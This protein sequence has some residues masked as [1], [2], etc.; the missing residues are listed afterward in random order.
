MTVAY[1]IFIDF[2]GVLCD[3]VKEAYL[4]SR[5]AYYGTDVHSPL[6]NLYEIFR[7]YRYLITN[8][9]Q[10]YFLLKSCEIADS[11][12]IEKTFD[13]LI[14]GGQN[15][16]SSN[17][18]NKFLRKRA[19]LINAEFDFWNQLE[20]PT[21]FLTKIRDRFLEENYAILSTKTKT[22]IIAKLKY[23]QV[24]FDED[25]IFGKEDIVGFTKGEFINNY[26]LKKNVKKAILIDDSYENIVS[27]NNKNIMTL[28]TDWGYVN[29]KK[30]G[31]SEK[32]ILD[33]LLKESV[34]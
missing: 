27:C 13:M 34:K 3:S 7:Q 29:P 25:L 19:E 15:V 8:S 33:I 1:A 30:N 5:Y 6:D 26:M 16:Q 28:L 4:L 18:N 12:S 11:V 17:F 31:H 21:S 14:S 9:W 10:Y 20:S 24:S 32:S 23:W 2:D 22:A